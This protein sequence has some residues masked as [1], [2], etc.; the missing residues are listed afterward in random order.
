MPA[1]WNIWWRW[2]GRLCYGNL[3]LL[4]LSAC[5]KTD[6]DYMNYDLTQYKTDYVGDAP[7]VVDIVSHQEYPKEYSYE[8]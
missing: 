5:G 4:S 1:I 3:R 6:E 7:N 8:R 2:D